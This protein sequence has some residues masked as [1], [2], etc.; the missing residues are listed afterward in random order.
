MGK[1]VFVFAKIA[2]KWEWRV[3]PFADLMTMKKPALNDAWKNGFTE[4]KNE[5]DERTEALKEEGLRLLHPAYASKFY[6]LWSTFSVEL[7]PKTRFR[8]FK[9]S[10]EVLSFKYSK[11][12]G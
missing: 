6:K 1:K 8:T 9:S 5:W 4:Y 10:L 12:G 3:T 7:E 11:K 2:G